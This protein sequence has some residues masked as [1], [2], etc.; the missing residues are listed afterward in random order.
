MS[1]STPDTLVTDIP[2]GFESWE[3][4]IDAPWPAYFLA[5]RRG[6]SKWIDYPSN[7]FHHFDK[8]GSPLFVSGFAYIYAG[9]YE[10]IV[11]ITKPGDPVCPPPPAKR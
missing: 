10:F 9:N 7:W 3:P 6:D 5:R 11:P 1:R 4:S 8:G 2:D